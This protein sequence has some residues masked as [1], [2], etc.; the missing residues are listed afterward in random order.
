MAR[1]LRMIEQK[2]VERLERMKD[3]YIDEMMGKCDLINEMI[4]EVK[5]GSWYERINKYVNAINEDKN[6]LLL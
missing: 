3:L 5:S 4:K 1:K 6:E 2:E